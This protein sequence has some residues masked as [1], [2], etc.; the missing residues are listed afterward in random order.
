[1]SF[2]MKH[3]QYAVVA[4]AAVLLVGCKHGAAT[5]LAKKPF[6]MPQGWKKFENPEQG[7][8]I[9]APPDWSI[10]AADS[11]EVTGLPMPDMGGSSGGDNPFGKMAADAE[12]A[13]EE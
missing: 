11:N 10:G 4:F 2:E 5:T 13:N 8:S 12:K 7:I 3:L 9:A 6:T 1:M